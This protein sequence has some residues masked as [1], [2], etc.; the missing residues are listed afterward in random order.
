MVGKDHDGDI[1][2]FAGD[3]P[4]LAAHVG[5]AEF[6]RGLG[7]A[8][9][10]RDDSGDA[11]GPADVLAAVDERGHRRRNVGAR[12]GDVLTLPTPVDPLVVE[13]VTLQVDRSEPLDHPLV[14]AVRIRVALVEEQV[15]QFLADAC[16][17]LLQERSDSDQPIANRILGAPIGS[18]PL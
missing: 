17:R 14:E 9:E 18:T 10:R 11:H 4:Q 6:C 16:E 7:H 15:A 13:G 3:G 8:G 12:R 2:L 5:V 1:Q